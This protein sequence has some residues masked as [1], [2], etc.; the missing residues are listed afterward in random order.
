M[1]IFDVV[2]KSEQGKLLAT[3]FIILGISEFFCAFFIFGKKLKQM[4]KMLKPGIQ[5]AQQ[6]GLEQQI[7]ANRIIKNMLI[8]IG[9]AAIAF[10]FYGLSRV[11]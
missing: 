10:G 6:H 11:Q 3:V 2:F 4:E 7:K 9:I 8:V 5:P 1:E